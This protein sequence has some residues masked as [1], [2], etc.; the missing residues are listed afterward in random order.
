VLVYSI[1]SRLH[2]WLDG[3]QWL[4][5]W[6]IGIGTAVLAIGVLIALW[7]L[8]DSRKTRDGELLADLSRRWSEHDME[9]SIMA[10]STHGPTGIVA[11]ATRLY[12]LP[13]D[14]PAASYEDLKLF[15]K[16]LRWPELI[17]AIAVMRA[18]GSISTRAVYKMWGPSIVAAWKAWEEP[19]K[20]LRNL[21]GYT[22][23]F[24][25]FEKLATRMEKAATSDQ[26]W[27]RR[28]WRW[29]RRQD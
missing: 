3:N 18:H 26:R 6:L 10:Y 16:L 21:E 9:E 15:T 1:W 14:A 7:G 11:L 24:P 13:P 4:A 19:A 20:T 25:Y 23:G 17:E 5:T 2:S 27:Y 28:F 22:G 29:L 12:D 8:R